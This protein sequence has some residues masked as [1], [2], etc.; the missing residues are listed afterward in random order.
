[1]KFQQERKRST[2]PLDITAIV[3]TVF[4]LLIFFAVSLSFVVLPSIQINLPKSS[5]KQVT[6]DQRDLRVSITKGGELYLRD[7]KVD[8]QELFH[9]FFLAAEKSANTEVLIGADHEVAHG[10]VVR[11]MDLARKAQLHRLAIITRRSEN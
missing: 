1:M 9:E 3:D 5:S 10:R 4:N 6:P 2:S 11:V 7:S 8:E